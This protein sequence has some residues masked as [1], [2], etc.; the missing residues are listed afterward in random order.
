MERGKTKNQRVKMS[1]YGGIEKLET[2]KSECKKTLNSRSGKS[3]KPK[4]K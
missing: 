2:R 4:A 3:E 1:E